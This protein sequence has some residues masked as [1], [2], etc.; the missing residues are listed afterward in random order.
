[1]N[2][3]LIKTMDLENNMQLNLYD[4]SRKLAG[5]RWLVSLIVRMEIPVSETL[6]FGDGQSVDNGEDPL[7]VLGEKVVFEQNMQRIFVDEREKEDVLKELIDRFQ[8]ST[9]QYLAHESFPQK[10]A[11]KMYREEKKK[12]SWHRPKEE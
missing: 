1:M 4:N 10:Y 9:L 8:E 2:E 6:L 3:K 5:D 12:R 11:K 7:A